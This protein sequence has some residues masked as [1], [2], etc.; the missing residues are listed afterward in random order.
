MSK[1]QFKVSRR[2]HENVWFYK[3]LT[4]KQKTVVWH[5]KKRAPLLRTTRKVS[6]TT[7]SATNN[8]Q[9]TTFVSALVEQVCLFKLSKLFCYQKQKSQYI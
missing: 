2:I 6:P 5:F 8:E 7:L 3:R 9:P 1:I 4:S